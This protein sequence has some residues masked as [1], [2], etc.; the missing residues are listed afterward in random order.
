[1]QL[2]RVLFDSLVADSD[3][4]ETGLMSIATKSAERASEI[5]ALLRPEKPR[6]VP[7][8]LTAAAIAGD[9]ERLQL[10]VDRGG[11][12][13]ERSA[14]YASPLAAACAVGE[15]ESVRWLIAH[16]A[17]L[18]PPGAIISP[19]QSALGKAN[20]EAAALL[21]DAGLPVE[22]GAWGVLAAVSLGRLDMLRWLLG[23]GIELD[24]S[25]PGI[26]V[27]RERAVR[28]ARKNAAGEIVG[29]LTG[30]LDPGPPPVTPPLTPPYRKVPPRAAPEV[31]PVLLQEALDLVRAAGSS[32]ARWNAMGPFAP[33]QRMLLIS[34]AAGTGVLEIVTA[35]LDAGAS[36]DFAPEGTPPPLS[37]AA[38][39]AQV[40]VM[41]LL[42]DR[43]ASPD[44]TD[45]R[46]WLPLVCAAES[47]EP[48]AVRTLLDAGAN[49]KAKPAGGRKLV[50]SA[51]GPFS[52]EI[53]ALIEQAIG[54]KT[55][56]KPK[57]SK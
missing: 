55:A 9:L 57:R 52:A 15:L 22:H 37:E 50:E 10:F 41:R 8:S 48:E 28:N 23:R 18:D 51:R 21:F 40:D 31:W 5:V 44:G 29:F 11:N 3:C 14:G 43:G 32:S 53:R 12:I 39:E 20:C 56:R 6:K 42:L 54:T 2:M 49:P 46:I 13:E 38:T 27:L 17:V 4:E 34:F 7:E 26:G 16:G 30:E 36:P 19:I 24:R 47:G 35:L 25:Y 1:M 33:P 45:G